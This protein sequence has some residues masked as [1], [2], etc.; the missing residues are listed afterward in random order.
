MRSSSTGRPWQALRT[1]VMIFAR[2]NGSV[3]PL[4]FTTAST[5]SSTVVNLLPHS[6]QCLRRRM[7]WPSSASRESTTRESAC[8]QYGHRMA[9]PSPEIGAAFPTGQGTQTPALRG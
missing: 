4:R 8:R 9:L 3:T 2:L 6:G 1:P 7:I 5:A